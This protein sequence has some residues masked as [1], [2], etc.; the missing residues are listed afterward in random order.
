[1]IL[2]FIDILVRFPH[3]FTNFPLNNPIPPN[4]GVI[5]G[6][7]KSSQVLYVMIFTCVSSSRTQSMSKYPIL[8]SRYY[9]SL[10][11][12]DKL[13]CRRSFRVSLIC[14]NTFFDSFWGSAISRSALGFSGL[15]FIPSSL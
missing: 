13:T 1:V 15:M 7:P 9:F 3:R 12:S 14:S 11:I 4:E 2:A 5:A 6:F 8:A 10:K